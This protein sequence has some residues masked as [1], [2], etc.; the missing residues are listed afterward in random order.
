MSPDH[1]T[2]N[3]IAL[4]GDKKCP[5]GQT[6]RAACWECVNEDLDIAESQIDRQRAEIERLRTLLR[7]ARDEWYDDNGQWGDGF[8]LKHWTRK[9]DALLSGE[10][11]SA[12]ETTTELTSRYPCPECGE[13]QGHVAAYGLVCTNPKCSRDHYKYGRAAEKA[14]GEHVHTDECWEPDSGC[15][16]GRNEVHAVAEERCEHGIPRRFCTAVHPS[17]NGRDE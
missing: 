13:E 5:H 6:K 17:E 7:I 2:S 11:G 16:M 4:R 12:H 3:P 14:S 9:A 15:D 8:G 1:P 10:L